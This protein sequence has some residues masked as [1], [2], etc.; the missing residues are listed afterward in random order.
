[1]PQDW[2]RRIATWFFRRER[3]RRE[4]DQEFQ[5][6]I[7]LRAATLRRAG[8]SATDAKLEA[9][10]AF[11]NRLALRDASRDAW[12]MQ[13]V[14]DLARDLRIA[15]RNLRKS[16][17]FT[18]AAILSL[19]LGIGANTAVF[20]VVDALLLEPL[21]VPRPAELFVF[22]RFD[23]VEH[24]ESFSYEQFAELQ[25]ASTALGD[26]FGF[27]HR[28]A[29]VGDGGAGADVSLALVSAGYFS[30]LRVPPAL[31]RTLDDVNGEQR[32]LT[33]A[34]ISDSFWRRR[35]GGSAAV[36][37]S[38]FLLNR[39]AYTVVGVMPRGFDGVSLDYVTDAWLRLE[40][41]PRIDGASALVA[42]GS[43][44]VR[45]MTRLP[46][47]SSNVRVAAAATALMARFR[48][49]SEGSP[50]VERIALT[51]ASRPDS[52]ARGRALS[53]LVLLF[54]LVGLLML[55]ACANVAHLLQ[56]RAAGRAREFFIRSAIGA[57]RS[58]LIRQLMAETILLSL[59][60]A[61]AGIVVAQFAHRG[62]TAY[63]S[64]QP[65]LPF[66]IP[67]WMGFHLN[68]TILAFT[69]ILAFLV[70][71]FMG[72][73][74]ARGAAAGL[75][76]AAGLSETRF[77]GPGRR[78]HPLLVS[79]LAVCLL[80]LIVAG[81]LTRSFQKL[82]QVDLGFRS[83]GVLQLDVN[84]GQAYSSEQ[85]FRRAIDLLDEIRMLP[86]V[87]SASASVPGVFSRSTWQ[88]T[89]RPAGNADGTLVHETSATPQFFATLGIPLLRGRDFR[90][91]DDGQA[92]PVVILSETAARICFS[93]IDPIGKG[94]QLNGSAA[95]V[96]V[97]GV[98]KD[99][100]LR[101]VLAPP[102]PLVYSPL[103][104]DYK[105][106][107]LARWITLEV[108]SARPAASLAAELERSVRQRQADATATVRTVDESIAESVVLRRLAAW[109]SGLF[110]LLGL[111]LASVGLYGLLS[112]MV[113]RRTSEIGIRLALGADGN[114]VLAQVWREAMRPV[115]AGILGG[116]VIA[117]AATRLLASYL[118]GLTVM[119]PW[120]VSV[121]VTTL[122]VVAGVAS[123][124][125]AR[126][127]SRIDPLQAL[128]A[129]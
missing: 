10:R 81:L 107:E 45:V 79:Q 128:R 17:T 64:A 21:N 80:L 23:A 123:Y 40:A 39:I 18:L 86:G 117:T 22:D 35:F 3:F 94:V 63:L 50:S 120:A 83:Q 27:A 109:L 7:E 71:V 85:L 59:L 53:P 8:L 116:L 72:V 4:L 25:R 77:G 103:L 51:S 65:S 115:V 69:I 13:W 104:Q 113:L 43:N 11:G 38:T 76:L 56:A 91:A 2:R 97:I 95:G 31:G 124:L 28:T 121:A 16:P 93:G 54:G 98:A 30:A 89:L 47:G 62:F 9:E 58:R 122:L 61:L 34:V 92:P 37:G 14:D 70:G 33:Q 19:A 46:P 26:V 41:Q 111:I 125:P 42:S 24:R 126:R 68:L 73:A 102:P 1:M 112:Y 60:G 49:S 15:G 74:P 44:W 129:E 67:V 108:R 110:G 101:D 127:A 78:M 99:I 87:E 100:R 119:D 20:S 57:G 84:W 12:G 75:N 106:G 55:I 29:S 90:T 88:G 118:F 32:A 66:A 114:R 6:H 105:S 36:L 52:M 96:E 82:R 48:A 5:L